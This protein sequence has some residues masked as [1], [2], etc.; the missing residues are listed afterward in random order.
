MRPASAEP[1][2]TPKI[3]SR[4]GHGTDGRNDAHTNGGP[5]SKGR[6]RLLVIEHANHQLVARADRTA[7]ERGARPGMTLASA[8]AIIASPE[9]PPVVEPFT[10]E[11]DARALRRLADWAHAFAPRVAIDPDPMPHVGLDDPDDQGVTDRRPQD[12]LM[13]DVSGCDRLYRDRSMPGVRGEIVLARSLGRAISRLGF[14][15]RIGLA[16]T[17]GAAWGA[18]RFGR[19]KLTA[20]GLEPNAENAMYDLR[21]CAMAMPVAALRLPLVILEGLEELGLDTIGDVAALS[22]D[23]VGSRFG[24]LPLLRIDQL[25]GE[26]IETFE[27]VRTEPAV[28]VERRFDGP[29]TKPEAIALTA[30][31]LLEDLCAQ[32]LSRESGVRDLTAEFE[33]LGEDLRRTELLVERLHLSRP[34]RD[35]KHLLRLLEPKIERLHL[36]HGLERIAITCDRAGRLAHEQS[37]IDGD[38]GATPE[39]IGRAAGELIDTLGARLGDRRVL[40][41]ETADSHVPERAFRFEPASRRDRRKTNAADPS[42]TGLGTRPPL[43]LE[44]PEPI[45]VMALA[46]DHP[47]VRVTWRGESLAIVS[48]SGPEQIGG[49]WW[50]WRHGT[51]SKTASNTDAKP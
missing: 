10:P 11:R 25:L 14:T 9:T 23:Q 35:A 30:R 6:P 5:P 22:R 40:R 15:C 49:E 31:I 45:E 21:A 24:R 39:R 4:T 26:A 33:R 13:L 46:P 16:P 1:A 47:P 7:V 32:M 38:R 3:E 19:S 28:R 2:T 48:G 29:V 44:R 18:A 8:R 37:S 12:A 36:G 50:R 20:I 42:P 17:L 51:G 43:L 27:P 41:A 34:S